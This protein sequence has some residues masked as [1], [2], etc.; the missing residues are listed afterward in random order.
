MEQ[1]LIAK[2]P[3]HWWY[4]P[5][6]SK[7]HL[8]MDQL[9][10]DTNSKSLFNNQSTALLQHPSSPVPFSLS[11]TLSSRT[12]FILGGL[13]V[14]RWKSLSCQRTTSVWQLKDFPLWMPYS[15]IPV[16]IFSLFISLKLSRSQALMFT[17]P[18]LTSQFQITVVV[19]FLWT[20]VSVGVFSSPFSF[21]PFL[22]VLIVVNILLGRREEV[23]F[24]R[25]GA[26]HQPPTQCRGETGTSHTVHGEGFKPPPPSTS[27]LPSL[28]PSIAQSIKSKGAVAATVY[29]MHY[30]WK[31]NFYITAGVFNNMILGSDDVKCHR[32]QRHWGRN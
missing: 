4:N 10:L 23:Y 19:C 9:L 7:T 17:P 22:S 12:A 14:I 28:S 1:P 5:A 26:M 29:Q 27:L 25:C 6:G 21:F 8:I 15:S 18:S 2:C 30:I 20:H 3:F 13:S 31:Q 11:F 16:G 24:K 32:A